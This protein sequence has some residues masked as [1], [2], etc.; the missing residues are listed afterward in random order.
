MTDLVQNDVDTSWQAA[1]I[2]IGCRKY[3]LPRNVKANYAGDCTCPIGNFLVEINT[4]KD[5]TIF[6][7]IKKK[8]KNKLFANCI[9]LY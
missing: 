7:S 3:N 8:K 1:T 2:V 5:T 6:F 9:R 4:V